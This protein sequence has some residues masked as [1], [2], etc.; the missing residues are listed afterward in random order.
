MS[1]VVRGLGPGMQMEENMEREGLRKGSQKLKNPATL[2]R[3]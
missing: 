1:R 3:R 2:F